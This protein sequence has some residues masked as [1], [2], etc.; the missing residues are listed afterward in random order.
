[1]VSAL[2]YGA[3]EAGRMVLAELRDRPREKRVVRGFLDD[4]PSKHGAV[5]DG[6]R[7]LGGLADLPGL[8][9]RH[10]VAQ[11]IIAMPS[12][13]KG[14]VRSIVRTCVSRRVKLLIVPSTREI[15]EGSVRFHQIKQ[16]DP[17]D[18]L[19]REQV[20]I[21]TGRISRFVEDRRVLVTGAAGSIGSA[22]V[23]RLLAYR[24]RAVA[25]L[26]IHE[27]GLFGLQRS[28]EEGGALGLTRVVPLVADIKM[29]G[30]LRELFQQEQPDIVFHAAA[31]KHV[32][33]MERNVKMLFL[34]NVAG[35]RTLLELC[36]E[37][38]VERFI[39]IST[40]KAVYPV[41][42]MGRTKRLCELLIKEYALRG[43][44]ASAVR[45][46]NV[47]GSNGSVVT[48][49]REQIQRGGPVTVTSPRM[50]RYF[51]TLDE[52]VSL[53]LQ[54]ATMPGTGDVY[55]LDMGDPIRI[56]DLAESMILLAG[57]TPG[58]DVPIRYTGAR[59]GEKLSE[60]LFHREA[61]VFSSDYPGITV[62][63]VAPV[64]GLTGFLD[65]M[66]AG[67]EEPADGDIRE[68]VDTLL[69]QGFPAEAPV[70]IDAGAGLE[71]CLKKG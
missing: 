54:S 65:G 36:L 12:V 11:V 34:N 37:H 62:E 28:L 10:G 43:L 41:S 42:M 40:D 57:L 44:A 27:N 60:E 39:G 3:G 1:M 47:L 70:G 30:M 9:Q 24:P 52:A 32:P 55:V 20:R 31:Y 50:A 63:K 68:A 4:D 46:G 64:E 14:V 45:F 71:K 38:G 58:T 49:F 53:V 25:A 56:Q 2:I 61:E 8:I 48:V 67:P 29:R 26:D 15:I 33:L 7:V 59:E 66:L 51:M 17:G 35:T 13:E 22:L 21:D 23:H 6:V 69:D 16:I 19:Q 18:L 5:V